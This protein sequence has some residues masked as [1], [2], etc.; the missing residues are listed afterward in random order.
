MPKV[1]VIVP[2]YNVASCLKECLNSITQQTMTDIEIILVD[3]GSTDGSGEVCER[4][5]EQDQ[6]ITVI[7]KA[8]SGLSSARNEGIKI[9]TAPYIM[10]VDGDDWVA[11]DFCEKPYKAATDN[12]ADIVIFQACY[13]KNGIHKKL[14]KQI[15]M[16]Q[17]EIVD[18]ETALSCGE[19]FA[20]NK[21]YKRE[22]FETATYPVGRVFED[23]AVT[24]K[25]ILA[26][27]TIVMLPDTLYFQAYRCGSITQSHTI[28]HVT[29]GLIA[30][31]QF[32]ED[33]SVYGY[34]EERRKAV[35]GSFALR[36]LMTTKVDKDPFHVQAEEILDS[37]ENIPTG[38]NWKKKMMFRCWKLDKR[39]FHFIC[40]VAG[41][42]YD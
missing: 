24:H 12:N 21:L 9:A 5:A 2:I 16:S 36:F 19:S 37:F 25:Y 41:Q 8:N 33:L 34:A 6:R 35:L 30:A 13:V 27:K 4:Y 23:V 40:R 15:T 7:H 29:D 31:L 32:S 3:D 28:E 10:F 11:A 14:C 22:L 1:S 42:K 38:L 17:I 18:K 39:L 26:S 20:W